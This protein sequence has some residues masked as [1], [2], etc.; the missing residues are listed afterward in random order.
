MGTTARTP[1]GTLSIG[2]LARV[3]GVAPETIR[4]WELRYGFPVALRLPSGHRRYPPEAATR[5]A[6]VRRALAAGVR[7]GEALRAGPAE[8]EALLAA[9]A[10]KAAES[11][12]IWLERVLALDTAELERGFTMALQA[13][14]PEAFAR[15]HALPFLEALG[16]AWRTGRIS[17]AQE[18]LASERLGE[19]LA[20]RWRPMAERARGPAVVAGTLPGEEHL[21]GVHLGALLLVGAGFRVLFVGRGCPVPDLAAT[22]RAAG[23][24]AVLVGVSRAARPAPV[25]RMLAELARRVPGTELLV[26]GPFDPGRA[27]RARWLKDFAALSSWA[28]EA[29]YA[30]PTQP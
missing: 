3:A 28:A 8:L 17:V 21:L 10:P 5:L 11:P 16:E 1:G 2:A 15:D 13:G 19:F 7:P 29:L 18:H 30:S 26:G 22:A 4:T 14:G 25:R 27:V 12:A 23:A 6:L 20:S 24:R 9:L